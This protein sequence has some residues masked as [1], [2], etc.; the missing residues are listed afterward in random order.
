M[1]RKKETPPPPPKPRFTLNPEL[2]KQLVAIGLIALAL[3]IL[4]SLVTGDRGPATDFLITSL[5]LFVG[6]GVILAPIWLVAAGAYL[7]LDSLNRLPNIGLERP[8][9]AIL[10]YL[11]ALAFIHLVVKSLG[12]YSDAKMPVMDAGGMVGQTVANLLVGAVNEAGAYILLVALMLVGIVMALNISLTQIPAIVQHGLARTRGEAFMP[13]VK[14]NLGPSRTQPSLIPPLPGKG[15]EQSS[16][17]RASVQAT[18]SQPRGDSTTA[19]PGAREKKP[20]VV[21]G[22][23]EEPQPPLPPMMPRIIGEVKHEWTLPNADGILAPNVEQ[24]LSQSEIRDRVKIIEQTLGQFGVPARVVEVSQGPTVTQF[25]IEPGF[26]DRKGTDGQSKQVKV[27]V[28]AIAGLAN[29]LAL[30]LAASPIRIEAPIPGRA[31]VG[32]EVP[33]SQTAL[34]S[35]RSVVESEPYVKEESRLKIALGQDVAGQPI[36]ADL[37]TMPHLLIA[38]A[39]G[40]GKSVCINAVIACLLMTNSPN[41]LNLVMVDPKMV[42]LVTYNGVPHLVMPVITDV[43]RVVN[44]LQ[45]AA[46]EMERRYKLFAT[47]GA[48]NLDGYNRH[49]T[50]LNEPKLPYL[51]IIIDELADLM[52]SRAEECEKLICRLAQMSRATGIHLI[53]ATQRPS[54]DV[55]TGL[56]KANFPARI[57]F[58]VTTQTDSRVILDGSGAEKLLGRGDMLYMSSDSSKLVRLQGCYV[59][60]DELRKLVTYWR[61]QVVPDGSEPEN[62]GAM[63]EAAPIPLVQRP[64]WEDVIAQQK[65]QAAAAGRDELLDKAIEVVQQHGRASVSLLQ[66][67]LRIGYSRAAR[68]ID[69]LEEDGVIGPPKEAGRERE[70]LVRGS[71]PADSREWNEADEE[72]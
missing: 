17:R 21:L 61:G 38:G 36:V 35:L 13:G 57:A 47:A 62:A 10:L 34:V 29:D 53:L 44:A 15:D 19:R 7:F 28:S 11:V 16:G 25:G 27:K 56:I 43:D 72:E 50:E 46:S 32:I 1:A 69:L 18:A 8:L 20:A 3:V 6:W 63:A 39:T 66:R 45:W 22:R 24:E 58:A 40:S 42:E 64:L 52:M 51:V 31:M 60:D 70:V 12:G 30:A 33:N 26:V 14:I 71:T 41:E 59:S 55:V 4:L 5:R 48:R 67:K 54:V 68:L 2:W 65:A 49:Q 9:G 37:G 23:A